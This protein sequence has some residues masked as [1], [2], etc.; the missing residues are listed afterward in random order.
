MDRRVA[1]SLG[2]T[3]PTDVWG[4]ALEADISGFTPLTESLADKLGEQRGAEE[5][6]RRLNV[7]YDGLLREVHRYGGTVLCFSGDAFTCWFDGDD[8][9]RAVSCGQALQA[10]MSAYGAQAGSSSAITEAGAAFKERRRGSRR[11]ETDSSLPTS[12][13]R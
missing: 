11:I 2:R 6:A 4:T 9:R 5:I 7:M 8:G 10:W 13:R 3:V 12:E 1:L